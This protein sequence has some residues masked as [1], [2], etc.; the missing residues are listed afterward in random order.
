S[1]MH[2]Q[3]A[4]EELMKTHTVIMIAHRLSTVRNVDKILVFDKG[5]I[6][7]EGSYEE[8]SKQDGLFKELLDSSVN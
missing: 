5:E 2:I 3:N 8:L 6:V 1:E 7:Q 4:M